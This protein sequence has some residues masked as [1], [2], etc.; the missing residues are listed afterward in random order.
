MNIGDGVLLKDARP[1]H[2]DNSKNDIKIL[3]H[4]YG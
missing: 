3:Y 1:L 4:T 2:E